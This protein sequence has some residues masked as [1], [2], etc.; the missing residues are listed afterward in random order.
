VQPKVM[1]GLQREGVTNLMFVNSTY[2]CAEVPISKA[3]RDTS[4]ISPRVETV[5]LPSLSTMRHRVLDDNYV[6]RRS[7]NIQSRKILAMCRAHSV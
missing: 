7:W 1:T 5:Q 2:R 4:A 6:R 3:F